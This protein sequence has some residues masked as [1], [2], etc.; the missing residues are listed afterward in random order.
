MKKLKIVIDEKIPFLNG[1]F[2]RYA[3]TLLLPGDKIQ[4]KHVVDADAMIVRTRTK[5]NRQLL[6]GT[7]VKCIATATIGFDHIDTDFCRKN[8]IYWNNAAGC[9][10][11]AVAQ[12]IAVALLK[13][14]EKF[15]FNLKD[16]TIGI[17]IGRAH[18]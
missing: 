6:E 16:M 18:V 7:R 9:N 2:D 1:V 8:N 17:E 4:L 5:C 13:T 15:G 10:S 11:G 12:Y 14:A 3:E